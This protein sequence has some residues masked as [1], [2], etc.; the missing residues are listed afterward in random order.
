MI[1]TARLEDSN[2]KE[3]SGGYYRLF[4]V[5][6]LGL[7]MSKVQG[8][9]IS[10][11]SELERMI[12]ARVHAI[13]DLDDFLEAEIMP[14]GVFIAPKKQVNKSKK[15][16]VP[17]GELDFLIFKRRD[18]QQRCYVV[19]LKDG[20]LFDT[21]KASAERTAIHS[22]VERNAP[23]LQYVVQCHFVDFNQD[24]KD[25][26]VHGFKNKITKDEAMTGREFCKLLEIDYD[27]IVGAR[28]PD[29]EANVQFFLTELV[30]IDSIRKALKRLL[31]TGD[32]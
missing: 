17:K 16:R 25:V 13:P 12:I 6:Q 2:P 9:V 11:G 23:M 27:E 26:I 32:D 28:R 30:K 18:G 14:E 10:S 29:Q 19:E 24:D 21:K 15:L 20:H 5:Q 31:K 1:S 7:L 8:T 22:F 3:T 4:G